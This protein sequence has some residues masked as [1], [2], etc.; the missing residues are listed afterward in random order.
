MW[1]VRGTHG[2]DLALDLDV[3][4]H[5]D[6]TDRVEQEP[7]E[8]A[9]GHRPARHP[10]Q[11]RLAPITGTVRVAGVPDELTPRLD[12]GTAGPRLRDLLA[13]LVGDMLGDTRT[14]LP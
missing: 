10:C 8:P 3:T 12:D 13:A 14:V 1:E 7:V 5:D 4:G 9:L 6:A 2:D 11:Q